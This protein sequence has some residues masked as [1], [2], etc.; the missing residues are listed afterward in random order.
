M[1]SL[2]GNSLVPLLK[3]YV[4]FVL[5]LLSLVVTPAMAEQ[6][7]QW[8]PETNNQQP[9]NTVWLNIK[10]QAV[11][12][13]NHNGDMVIRHGDISLTLAYNPANEMMKRQENILVSQS[14]DSPSLSGLSIMVAFMF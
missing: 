13:L 11:I 2:P 10:Q 14:Q 5:I 8:H 3:R 1:S 9:L 7:F 6:H 4:P 12:G